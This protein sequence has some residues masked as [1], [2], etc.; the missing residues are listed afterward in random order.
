MYPS[1]FGEL[2]AVLAIANKY[3]AVN[4][5]CGLH[6][7]VHAPEL[8]QVSHTASQIAARIGVEWSRIEQTVLSYTPLSR[9]ANGNC[10]PGV[11]P[12]DRYHALN[13]IPLFESS[14]RTIEF[15]S[16]SATLNYNKIA[17]WIVFCTKFVDRLV[18]NLPLEPID[19][20]LV[21]TVA[22]KL[23]KP[24][25]GIEFYLHRPHPIWAIE[26]K[27]KQ[28]EFA[29]LKQAWNEMK[30]TLKLPGIGFLPDFRF[31]TYGNAMTQ[32]CNELGVRGV[33]RSFIEDRYDRLTKKFG[34]F[35]TATGGSDQFVD[36]EVDFYNEPLLQ[37]VER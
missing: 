20:K 7:H 19:P 34:F 13:I 36:D 26:T 25:G 5:S 32:L 2:K 8:F 1:N 9:R 23:I 11:V 31:P 37:Q 16:H 24:R 33:Y 21:L 27:H 6:V 12:S 15:R 18:A 30:S 14:R 29:D 28:Q 22:P 4:T 17:S 35:D 3:G 10:M